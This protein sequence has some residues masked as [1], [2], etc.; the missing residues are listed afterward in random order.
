M[1]VINREQISG[2]E[3]HYR[4]N[5][6]NSLTGYKSLN[7][8][9]T[10]NDDGITNLCLVSSVFHL[11]SNPPLIGL[12]MRPQRPNNDTLRN[13]RMT[14]QYTLNNVLPEWYERAHQTSANY[15]GGVSEF[16]ECGFKRKYAGR[17]KVPFVAES[18]VRIGL[19][20]QEI[21][22]MDINGTS[23]V[24]GEVI[25][26]LLE[27]DL[28]GEDGF[29]DPV[30]ALTMA[31]AGLDGYYLPQAV[32]RLAYAKPGIEPHQSTQTLITP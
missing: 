19:Q 2:M 29:I 14:G 4:T 11:G 24:I 20:L 10:I 9:G 8:V 27:D 5:L 32:A 30:K 16:D 12:V 3:K 15:P 13:I 21:I 18:T 31:G 23:L 6:V 1:N 7:L 17:F 25:H 28:V 22:D 26:V